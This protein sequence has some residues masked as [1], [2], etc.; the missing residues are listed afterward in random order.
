[1]GMQLLALASDMALGGRDTAQERGQEPLRLCHPMQLE[2][3][4]AYPG[5]GVR[6][7]WIL[8]CGSFRV[9]GIAERV[10]EVALDGWDIKVNIHRNRHST[11]TPSHL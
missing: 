8:S 1:M 7:M 5:S 10:A 2:E 11:L 6:M 9:H 3:Q 4:M